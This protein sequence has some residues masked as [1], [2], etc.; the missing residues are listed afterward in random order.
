MKARHPDWFKDDKDIFSDDKTLGRLYVTN[1]HID[2]QEG[3]NLFAKMLR[4]H[5]L[6]P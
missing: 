3:L 1:Y 2:T 5:G 6:V 4:R